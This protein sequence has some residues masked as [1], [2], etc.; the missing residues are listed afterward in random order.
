M[1]IAVLF[2]GLKVTDDVV[3]QLFGDVFNETT[4]PG[5]KGNPRQAKLSANNV[6]S[7]IMNLCTL[8]DNENDSSNEIESVL[9]S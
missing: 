5:S 2:P 4:L 7:V 9:V 3:V 1:S 8:S 6:V